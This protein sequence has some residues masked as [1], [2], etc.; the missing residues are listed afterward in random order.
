MAPRKT[1][2]TKLNEVIDLLKE[3]K[4]SQALHIIESLAKKAN[5]KEAGVKVTRAPNEYNIFV[6]ENFN[7]VKADHPNI[8]NRKIMTLIGAEWKKKK[9][10]KGKKN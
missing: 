3:K 2:A 1:L 8:D 5:D 10:S 4:V 7:R 9:V 6:K